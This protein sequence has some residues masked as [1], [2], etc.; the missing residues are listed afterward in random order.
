MKR[1]TRMQD[2]E[3]CC[4]NVHY[5]MLV[6]NKYL[7]ARHDVIISHDVAFAWPFKKLS[8]VLPHFY[9]AVTAA[10]D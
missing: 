8:Q 1:H 5:L 10:F 3:D 9:V 7:P 2:C 6:I 4:S